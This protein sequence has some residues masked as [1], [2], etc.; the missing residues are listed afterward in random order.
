MVN[1]LQLENAKGLLIGDQQNLIHLN[2]RYE[3][4]KAVERS[5]ELSLLMDTFN[6]PDKHPLQKFKLG[7]KQLF[8]YSY[9]T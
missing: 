5:A 2:T 6:N 4:T 3:Q 7:R 8:R 1:S 9:K